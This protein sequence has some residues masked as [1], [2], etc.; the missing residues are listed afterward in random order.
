MLL[1]SFSIE[2]DGV[3]IDLHDIMLDELQWK[4]FAIGIILGINCKPEGRLEIYT[5]QDILF[6]ILQY[7][8]LR[9][10]SAFIQVV[11]D[12]SRHIQVLCLLILLAGDVE[13]NPGPISKYQNSMSF[14]V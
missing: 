7:I 1:L 11:T 5:K 6:G 8:Q 10:Q 3:I 14:P 4:W 9:C 13:K 2:C 12:L